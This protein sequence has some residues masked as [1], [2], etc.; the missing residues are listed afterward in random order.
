M[1]SL[2]P[3]TRLFIIIA[4]SV[5]FFVQAQSPGG[6]TTGLNLWLDASNGTTV[7]ANN[8]TN[9]TD[10]TALNTFT[11]SATPPTVTA[12]AVNFHSA[13]DFNNST[14]TDVYPANQ[15]LIG[16]TAINYT[17]AYAVFKV[18]DG[19]GGVIIGGTTPGGSYGKAI[20][21]EF[22]SGIHSG[23]GDPTSYSNYPFTDFEN[24]HVFGMDSNLAGNLI[25]RLD[26]TDQ[27]VTN[28]TGFSSINLVPAIG[29]TNNNGNLAGWNHLKGQIAEV[30]VYDQTTTTQRINIESYLALKYGIHKFGN[31]VDSS[32]TIIWDAIANAAYHN[33]V[34]GLGQDDTSGLLQ[35]QSN[36]MN[37]GSGDGTG[38]SGKGNIVISSP[39]S[40][41]NNSFLL[42]GHN[43]DDFSFVTTNLP[44][45]SPAGFIR[46]NRI[47]KTQTTGS[48]G[49]ISLDFDTTGLTI[50]GT[51]GDLK[52]IIDSDGDGNFATGTIT[53][54]AVNSTT[55]NTI[56]FT[57]VNFPAGAT[58]TFVAVTISPGGITTGLNMWLDANTGITITTGTENK[59]VIW[60][61][62]SASAN[63]ASQGNFISQPLVIIKKFNFNQ[64][65]EL[66]G[67]QYMALTSTGFAIGASPRSAFFVAS[68][69]GK[70]G[71]NSWIFSYGTSNVGSAWAPGKLL[72][73]TALTVGGYSRDAVSSPGF[74]ASPVDDSLPKLG[75]VTFNGTAASFYDK[76]N[77]IGTSTVSW[78]TIKGNGNLGSF[79]T[80]GERWK[81][82]IA[83]II[84]YSNEIPTADREKIES[85]L[86]L[87][88][89]IHKAGNYIT[90]ANTVIWDA[91][92]NSAYHND[93]FGIGQDD[94]S[95]L[96][97]AQSNS[98]NTGGGDGTGQTG[99]GN[100]V[101]SNPS[102]L[103]NSGF[104]MIG[105][106]TSALTETDVSVG[107]DLTK[108][109]QRIWKVQS[110]GNPGNVTLS[111]DITGLTYSAQS[112]SD[113]VLLVDPTGAGN[114]NGGSVMKYP[115]AILSGSKVSFNSVDLLTGSVFTFQTLSKAT[116]QATNVV[117]ASTTGTTTTVSWTNGNGSSR[118]VFMYAGASG[119]PA[120]V[121]NTTYTAN[122]AFGTG[123]QIGATGWYCVY[124]GTGT[125]VNITGL[126]P[127]TTYQLMAVEYNGLTGSELYLTTVSTG[128]PAAVTTLN[129]VATLS[130]L[131]SSAGT[132]D[133]VFASGTT[134]YTATVSNAITS[135]TVTPTT[136]DT[137]AT[138]TV[139][140][141]AVTS[142]SPSGAIAL[143]VGP[144]IITTVVTAQD[145]TTLGTYTITVTRTEPTIVTTGSLSALT[146][147]Y[148]TASTSGS[149]TV[150]GTDMY[151]GILVTPPSGFEVS[152]DDLIFSN[153]VTIGASGIIASTPVYI[154]LKGTI[155]AGSY[156]GDVVLTSN[157]AAA[158]NVATVLSTVTTAAL[159]ITADNQTKVY[160]DAN[161]ILTATYAGFVNGDTETNLTTP[162]VITTTADTTSPVG[163]YA[164]TASGASSSNYTIIYVDGTLD[165]TKA[166]VTI[167]ADNKNKAYG[168]VNPTLTATY[169]GFVNGDTETS[170]TTPPAITTTADTTSPVGGYPITASGA[171]SSNYTIVYVDGTLD[172][173]KAVVTI[174]ADNKNK[175]YGDVNP[176]LT[177]TY[178]G[179]VN[180]DTI[181][182]LQFSL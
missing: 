150:S 175:V 34:F 76:G 104:L 179:F 176:T 158:V 161:P 167:T 24:Y 166:I 74:W 165:V 135:L 57:D 115:A 169:T 22:H 88:Y 28:S 156:S 128:N 69:N 122:A 110:T 124:N 75:G 143:A 47:W 164:I 117:F 72:N 170:L 51:I 137:N 64:A 26:G 1:I 181:K 29:T 6:V 100:I 96:L 111:Y 36:S 180:G 173:T 90:S 130:N 149:F 182:V 79:T 54:A 84:Y 126:T 25:G 107:A 81:G 99:K 12:N 43:S 85:Y 145:G 92:I 144:N 131:S 21:A 152:T 62:K 129:N 134:S 60:A 105:H 20:F 95:G 89:G 40:I 19:N 174:T 61:D 52:L 91:T 58:F 13:V 109:I 15:N 66:D 98:T 17:D 8:L 27:S 56:F 155:P 11:V 168:D 101:I 121:D 31:Y 146:T 108:R 73:N 157:N 35:T 120:P 112:A 97:Q 123:T 154:R 139:N 93:V 171:A 5:S 45:G 119:S 68:E 127:A 118:A 4:L 49:T 125:T 77:G 37:T 23:N 63:N 78:N 32:N 106:N 147:T 136:T 116:V 53:T 82:N 132:L 138:V 153:T 71:G 18:N 159:T 2:K 177:A 87:K 83:E 148:G 38:K 113:Y 44:V 10:K 133:P 55:G 162:P 46:M 70:T 172:V 142:G 80:G 114:F 160:G 42:L 50:P 39:S 86:A 33:D 141:V 65:L 41:I 178:T 103:V 94:P 7:S 59:V 16:N 9:W 30:I 3:K 151:E 102:S 140:S 48:V 14:S 67:N 163:G